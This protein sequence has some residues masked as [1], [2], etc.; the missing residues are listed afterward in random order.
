MFWCVG[1]KTARCQLQH[2]VPLIA[3]R[4]RGG[5]GGGVWSSQDPPSSHEKGQ[6]VSDLGQS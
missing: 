1:G 5:V 6:L 3:S 2:P 4:E